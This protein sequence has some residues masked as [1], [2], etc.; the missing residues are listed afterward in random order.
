MCYGI[1]NVQP[2]KIMIDV[3]GSL[4]ILVAVALFIYVWKDRCSAYWRIGISMWF[5]NIPIHKQCVIGFEQT[6]NYIKNS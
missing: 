5:G 1:S 6:E 2:N 4:D 3:F